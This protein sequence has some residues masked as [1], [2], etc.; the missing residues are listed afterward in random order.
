M[1]RWAARLIAA[2]LVL[3]LLIVLVS[4]FLSAATTGRV[5][6]LLSAEG[7]RW[8]CSHLAQMLGGAPLAYLLTV[9]MAAGCLWQSR[10]LQALFRPAGYR[11]RMALRLSL[12][13]ASLG[14]ALLV[15]FCAAPHAVLL[16]ATGHLWPSPFSRA[17]VPLLSGLLM[18]VASCY[19]L[20][21]RTLSSF[22]DVVQA[23]CWGISKASPL[24]V[25]CMLVIQI[26]ESLCYVFQ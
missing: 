4:W 15:W 25:L 11:Q 6:S 2:M 12:V 13:P 22:S 5:H 26:Y 20:A 8:L 21:S 3:L 10:L 24:I 1:N 17:L 18:V 9:S 23:V 19:G 16:S 14:V 7:M